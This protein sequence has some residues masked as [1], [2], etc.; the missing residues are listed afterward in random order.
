MTEIILNGC[1]G[2]MGAAVTKAVLERSDCKI[3]AGVDLYGDN[4]NYP[5]YRSFA[6]QIGRAHV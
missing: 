2:K 4:V 3:V 1:N 5:V 6:D